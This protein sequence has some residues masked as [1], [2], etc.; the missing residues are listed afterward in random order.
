MSLVETLV[1]VSVIALMAVAVMLAIP[2]W[3][4]PEEDAAGRLLAR[5]EHAAE[6]A[7]LTG[8]V[9][10]F[11]PDADGRGYAFVRY[12]DGRWRP[13]QDDP[14]LAPRTLGE[15]LSLFREDAAPIRPGA[16]ENGTR[17]LA[18]EV[19]FDPTG[20]D[21]PFVYRLDG[22]VEARRVIRNPDG[23]LRV[24]AEP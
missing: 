12:V 8:A 21:A 13:M 2:R 22:E 1:A 19:W 5:F 16:F 6:R 11:A 15:G 4:S 20:V 17:P 3:P 10:G 9:I 23:A 14:A 18:P 7:I 24:E